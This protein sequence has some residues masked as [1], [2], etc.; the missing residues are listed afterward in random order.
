M[1]CDRR[2][3]NTKRVPRLIKDV[4][5][6]V[7]CR[8]CS[9]RVTWAHQNRKR[10]RRAPIAAEELRAIEVQAIHEKM[11]GPAPPN[12]TLNPDALFRFLL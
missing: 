6:L 1:R 10:W 11:C 2:F 12:S 7:C 4:L 3:R 5:D 8:K 9:D